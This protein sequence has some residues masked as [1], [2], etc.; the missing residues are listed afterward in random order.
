MSEF[1]TM[2]HPDLPDQPIRVRAAKTGPRLAAG[3]E[4]ATE[5]PKAPKSEARKR[6]TTDATDT[7]KEA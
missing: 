2:T 1:V 7:K 6:R 5:E 4:I 3:W